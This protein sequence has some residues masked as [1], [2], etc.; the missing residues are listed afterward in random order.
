MS[1]SVARTGKG[2]MVHFTRLT[3]DWWQGKQVGPRRLDEPV[4]APSPLPEDAGKIRHLK[5]IWVGTQEQMR[6]WNELM[7]QDHP[8]GNRPLVGRQLRYLV[9]SEHGWLGGVGFSAA[10]LHLEA[11]DRWIGLG[12]KA[13]QEGLH[14]VVNMTRMLIREGVQCRNLVSRVIGM[15]VRRMPKDFE[16]RYGY[17]PLLL[18]SFVDTDASFGNQLQ[19]HQLAL[20]GSN[21]RAWSSRPVDAIPREHQ[22]D[23]C[24]SVS[25]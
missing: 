15:A 25:G 3:I 16:E 8:Q 14:Y 21:Q 5:L 6:L 10:A 9:K 17:R 18:E 23:L 22:S 13:R 19:G 24:V 1:Q 4:A 7:I 11:R 12:L 20:G 2:R